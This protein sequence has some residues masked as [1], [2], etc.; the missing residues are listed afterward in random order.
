ML[1]EEERVKAWEFCVRTSGLV[2]IFGVH[3]ADVTYHETMVLH[4]IML[5]SVNV[6][7]T[8]P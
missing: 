3:P 2:V 7:M 6:F 8:Y 4:S 5:C 1:Q